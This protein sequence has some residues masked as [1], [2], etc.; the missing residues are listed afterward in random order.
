MKPLSSVQS[1]HYQIC[2]ILC[3][4]ATVGNTMVSGSFLECSCQNH[5]IVGH[6]RE[7]ITTSLPFPLLSL[8]SLLSSPFSFPF[9]P[10]FPPS[11]PPLPPSSVDALGIIIIIAVTLLVVVVLICAFCCCCCIWC[12]RRRKM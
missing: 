9:H 4:H 11:L 3:F 5:F 1:F 10:L 6:K 8:S 2:Y 7:L 12:S